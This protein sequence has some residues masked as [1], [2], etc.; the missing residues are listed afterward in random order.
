[1]KNGGSPVPKV[2]FKDEKTVAKLLLVLVMVFWGGSFVASK[3]GLEGMYPVELA[4]LRFAIATPLLLAMTV[5]VFGWKSL[6]IER[7]DLLILFG[8]AMTGITLQYIVQLVAMTYTTVTNTVLLINMG[9]FFVLIPA[10]LIYKE[11]FKADNWLGVL[12]AFFGAAL[13]IT[14]GNFGLTT[15][16]I[17]DGL[18]LISAALWAVY[19]LIGNRLAGKYSVLTQLNYIFIIGF[20]GLLPFY[21]LTPRHDIGAIS[22]ISWGSLLYL[23]VVC[24][25]IAYFFFNDAIIK[26]GPSKTAIYQYFEPFFG[27]IFAVLLVN[28][29]LTAFVV[30]GG[31][32]I[33]AGIALADNNLKIIGY[34]KKGK[35]KEP[36]IVPPLEGHQ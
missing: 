5:L 15:N 36:V 27:I 2:S 28:E 25:I 22:A 23:A 4:T 16:I 34:F 11:K 20:L 31:A 24:S 21:A 18:V 35:G 8:M 17:G 7:R 19:V 10:V 14:K 9:S 32:L 33:I 30:V 1:M 26:I 29:P 12:I 6:K 13:I 3:V